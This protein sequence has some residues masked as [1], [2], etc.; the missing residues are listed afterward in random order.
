MRELEFRILRI[1][2][3]MR[4]GHEVNLVSKIRRNEKF[5]KWHLEEGGVDVVAGEFSEPVKW[6]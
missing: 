6:F 2:K 4:G 5:D 1:E 3:T